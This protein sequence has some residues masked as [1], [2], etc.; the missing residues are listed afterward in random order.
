MST[1]SIFVHK[2]WDDYELSKM[3]YGGIPFPIPPASFRSAVDYCGGG[4]PSTVLGNSNGKTGGQS[5][6]DSKGG[7][8]TDLARQKFGFGA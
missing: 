3:V 4:F 5:C 2:M 8:T 6:T 1:D 7:Y